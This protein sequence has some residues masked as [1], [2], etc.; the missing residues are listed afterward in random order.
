MTEQPTIGCV[1]QSLTTA[2]FLLEGKSV[3]SGGVALEACAAPPSGTEQL[4]WVPAAQRA[5]NS[6][7]PLVVASE[8]Y[9]WGINLLLILQAVVLLVWAACAVKFI[10]HFGLGQLFF[11]FFTSCAF[12]WAAVLPTPLGLAACWERLTLEPKMDHHRTSWRGLKHA[13]QKKKSAAE[14]WNRER[15]QDKRMQMEYTATM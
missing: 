6:T 7:K 4:L 14:R 15:G 9:A 3:G 12:L 8:L 13:G 2:A 10:A 11:F 1:Y 5:S